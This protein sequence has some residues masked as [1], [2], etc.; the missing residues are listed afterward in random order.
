MILPKNISPIAFGC[1]PLGGHNWGEVDPEAIMA[2]VPQA[3]ELGVTLF[4]TADCYGNG[5]SEERLGKALGRRRSDVLVASKFGVRIGRNGKTFI[6]NTP[7]WIEQAIE[8]TLRRLDTDYIDIY[9]LHWWDGVTPFPAIFETLDR[10]VSE[11]KIRAY[12]STNVTLNMMGLSSVSQLPRH[13]VT[14]SMEF[15]LVQTRN[16]N[17]IR[18]MRGKTRTGRNAFLAWG[19]LGGGILTGKYASAEGLDLND[20]RLK[21]PDSH[22]IGDRLSR[23]LRIVDVCREIAA[24]YAP[25]PT[26]AQVALQWVS[27]TL[28]FGSCLV[29]IKSSEQL[30]QAVSSFD[31]GLTDADVN[32]LDKAAEDE[33]C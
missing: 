32:R 33:I 18:A 11:G 3:I 28:G 4:D 13:F 2:A 20:R 31:F 5:L 8:G 12:G 15:S 27:R 26:V 19:P 22:F 29:G 30:R 6:D 16:R 21:R 25:A 10:L 17:A 23:N 7:V 14:N 24:K 1:D 9:Q